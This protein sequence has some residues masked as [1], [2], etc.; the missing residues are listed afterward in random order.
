M[1]R[2]RRLL[3]VV[4]QALPAFLSEHCFDCVIKENELLIYTDSSVWASQLRFYQATLLDA[5][6]SSSYAIIIN[7][8][9]IRISVPD[10][11]RSCRLR[12]PRTPSRKIIGDIKSAA[13]T[14]GDSEVRHSLLRLADALKRRS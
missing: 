9:H 4:R 11:P 10:L 5:I 14:S 3:H 2:H 13:R 7:H 6:R 12:N 1:E 8:I